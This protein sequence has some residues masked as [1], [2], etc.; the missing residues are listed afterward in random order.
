M[1]SR[2]DGYVDDV[3]YVRSFIAQQAPAWLDH[4]ALLGNRQP[5]QRE[6]G[7]TW[8]DLGCGQ[9][10]SATVFAAT[11]PSGVFH[12]IDMMPEHIDHARRF[13][14]EAAA[15]NAIF[16]TADFTAAAELGLPQFDYI[17]AHGVYAWIAPENQ[18]AL[19]R[20]I[21][22]HLKPGG[23]VYLSYNA[24]PGWATELPFQRL[25]RT[26]GDTFAGNSIA[27]FAAASE[28][29]RTLTE[30]K[31]PAL[32]QSPIVKALEDK[33]RYPVAYL[34]H[35]YMNAAWQP[36]FVNEV[37]AATAEFGLK[38]VGSATLLDNYGSFVLG[39]KAREILAGIAD[40]DVRELT[41]DFFLDQHFR[42][43]VFSRGD[44]P[45][46]DDERRRR[47]LDS[48]FALVRPNSAIEYAT[49]TPAGRL[50]FDNEAARFIV[51]ELAAGPARLSDIAARGNIDAQDL[52]ANALVLSAASVIRPVEAGHAPVAALNR[53]ILQRLADSE[54][55][56]AVAL[57]CGTMVKPGPAALER[58]RD[59]KS[60]DG[61]LA[62]WR[63]ILAPL[64]S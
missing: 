46:D 52:L 10:V 7:F 17:V 38:P 9:G 50:G 61:D 8:C 39:G 58:L 37:R 41:R 53:A 48:S 1:I 56:D 31:V 59:G 33:N 15:G 49:E 21:D 47:L 2:S 55:I 22:R 42:R 54:P 16:H 18:K 51:A 64:L 44:R 6:D 63:D 14:D 12:G 32:V 57:P 27:R 5:P 43:D 13:A 4:V 30:M 11:H 24:M 36:L 62:E 23:L 3:P 40:D 20:F 45:I 28:V 34:A 19:L 26:L 60:F 29:I 25:V 35:E